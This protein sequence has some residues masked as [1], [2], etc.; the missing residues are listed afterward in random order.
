[1]LPSLILVGLGMGSVFADSIGTATLGVETHEAGIASAVL[2]TSQQVGGSVGT[3]LFSTMFASAAAGYA[4][5]H[6]HV[7]NL[8]NAAA[9]HG[10][11]TAFRWST[12]IYALRLLLAAFVLPTPRGWR[13]PRGRAIAASNAEPSAQRA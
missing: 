10:E 13:R 2:N 5:T 11:A 9:V 7:A 3:A 12:G 1:V 6:I 4:A 8:A